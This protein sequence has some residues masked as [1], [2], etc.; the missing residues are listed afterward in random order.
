[1]TTW[2]DDNVVMI[3]PGPESY[4]NVVIESGNVVTLGG[5]QSLAYT[6]YSGSKWTILLASSPA[7]DTGFTKFAGNP[8][9]S[10][11]QHVACPILGNITG[12]HPVMY[13]QKSVG[14]GALT[15]DIYAVTFPYSIAGFHGSMNGSMR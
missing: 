3:A 10:D 7:P 2:T 15:W 4:D 1:M 14:G 6:G 9:L 5:T 13:Y 8:V 11:A 12:T